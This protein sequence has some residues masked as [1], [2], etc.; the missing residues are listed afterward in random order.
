MT[1]KVA[2]TLEIGTNGEGEVVVVHSDLKP[3]EN[4][5]GHIVFS[6]EQA[7]NFARLLSGKAHEAYEELAAKREAE[8]LKN[9]PP[10][11]RSAQVLA[12]GAPVPED[13]SHTQLRDDGQQKGYVVLTVEERAKGFVRPYRDAYKHIGPPGPQFS[14]RDL[15]EEERQRYSDYG[16]VKFE[17]YPESYKGS[18]TVG[19]FWTQEQLNKRGMGCGRIT[20][21][22]RAIAET[23][24]RDPYF[25][26]GTFC[27]T[28]RD[29]FP[30][31]E[32][33]EFVW[34]EMNGTDGPKVG[35]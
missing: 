8:R 22:S 29:H 32:D 18:N 30:I 5:V 24:A 1:D 15:T 21:M 9:V 23:Y 17:S 26:Q 10:V 28:C 16:Y 27:S 7:H 13:R 19:R 4:G 31:G 2:G 6:V 20:I 33:G 34:Y 25:Y 3:D 14:V 11:D 12:S 35:T